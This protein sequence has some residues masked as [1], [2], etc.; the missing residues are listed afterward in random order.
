MDRNTESTEAVAHT[1]PSTKPAISELQACQ[2][3]LAG[4]DNMCQVQL[5]QIEAIATTMLRAMETPKFWMSPETMMENLGLIQYLAADLANYVNS[6][7]EEVG[8]NYVDEIKR[9]QQ[10]RICEAFLTTHR[11]EVS[12]G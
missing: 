9:T 5:G 10:R 1:F 6:A 2:E 8:C 3:Q 4:I 7:A 12:H 11:D